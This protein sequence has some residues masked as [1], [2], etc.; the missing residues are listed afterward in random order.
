MANLIKYLS[1]DGLVKYDAKIKSFIEAKVDEGDAKSFKSVNLVDGV[2]K[3]YTVNP[4][5]EDAVADFEIEL[6]EQDLSHLMQ[7][8]KDATENNVA[9]FD[10]NG[11]VKDSGLAVA[12][13]A[14][15]SDVESVQG[16]VD[17]LSTF[18]GEIPTGYSESTIVAYINK[19]AQ[20]TR[21]NR[22]KLRLESLVPSC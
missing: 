19:K 10:E 3:F 14:T 12:D 7:L 11:Q 2:L 6:P 18:V 9:T 5:T 20:E 21:K 4:I 13:I 22:Q 17:E 15:K 1:L 16:N 8:V